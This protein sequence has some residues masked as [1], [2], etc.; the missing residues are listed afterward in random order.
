MHFSRLETRNVCEDQLRC[1]S[2]SYPS[3]A[4]PFIP[5]NLCPFTAALS[6]VHEQ[7]SSERFNSAGTPS[8]MSVFHVSEML[9]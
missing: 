2:K 4:S 3:E 1:E 7:T 8:L 5:G 9:W 6:F